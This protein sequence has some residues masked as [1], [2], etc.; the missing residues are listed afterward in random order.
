[1]SCTEFF[2]GLG[3]SGEIQTGEQYGQFKFSSVASYRDAGGESTQILP[4]SNRGRKSGGVG[5]GTRFVL[6]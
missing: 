4:V 5:G 3:A 6:R 2:V 1:M